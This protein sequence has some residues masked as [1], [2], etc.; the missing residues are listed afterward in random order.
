MTTAAPG[1]AAKREAAPDFLSAR[2]TVVFVIALGLLLWAS[3]GGASRAVI[4]GAFALY[5]VVATVWIRGQHEDALDGNR[6]F[7]P[8]TW[9]VALG[10][11]AAVLFGAGAVVTFW[12][13]AWP[14]LEIHAGTA[15]VVGAVLLYL[16]IGFLLVRWRE[17][18]PGIWLIAALIGGGAVAGAFGALRLGQAHIAWSL[19][20]L[21]VAL[22]ALPAGVALLSEEAIER[23]ATEHRR[24][25]PVWAL[26]SFLVF[27]GAACLVA[28]RL[29][30][31]LVL[32]ACAGLAGLVV[33]LASS[34]LADI[35]VVLALIAF[36]GITPRQAEIGEGLRPA[37]TGALVALGD[38]YMSG[39]GAATFFT[40]T[41]DGGANGCRRSPTAWAAVAGQHDF[42]GVHFLACSGAR[43]YNV[44]TEDED[45]GP[46][47][48]GQYDEGLSEAE[49]DADPRP[50][51]V[52]QLAQYEALT[53]GAAQAPGLVVISIG[54]NDVGFSTIGQMC[55]APGDCATK[56]DLWL[57]ALH[58]V[59]KEI[60]DTLRE[61]EG[62]FPEGTPIAVIPYPSP[63]YEPGPGEERTC[64][65]VALKASER[66]FISDFVD[67]LND[68]IRRAVP[69]DADMSFVG[70]MED[71]LR[72]NGLQLCDPLNGGRP[73]VNFIG[74]RSV[75]GDPSQRFN[76]AN[77]LHNSLHPNERGH[78]AM[79][80]VFREWWATRDGGRADSAPRA[81]AET[82]DV[83]G[84]LE[85]Q[86]YPAADE[87]RACRTLGGT[88]A[89]Q[90]TG[91]TLALAG[92][93]AGLL[94]AVAWVG[95]VCFFAWRRQ[96]WPDLQRSRWSRGSAAAAEDR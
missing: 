56:G 51:P 24:G 29:D 66:A 82:C 22:L 49:K 40:G 84:D 30:S 53:R 59:R 85:V 69:R 6:W 27:A 16:L 83:Y 88:W 70:G 13:E 15:L 11:G 43:T 26:A 31:P 9:T 47:P 46:V 38:S 96:R 87:S 14:V 12:V 10:A 58:D 95:S 68:T 92:S 89:L 37:S 76:P 62:A 78:A 41:D 32:V 73:G 7:L 5:A 44:R 42:A 45:G 80:G 20:P 2:R 48:H 75:N 28:Y 71:A 8:W 52:T 91:P 86:Y 4:A 50:E 74:I 67:A 60:R 63:I 61:V 55:V 77:W 3:Q 21:G 90:R 57:G 36:V 23:L 72:R 79:Y 93:V 19:V 1:P 94:A 65:D 34:T 18:S 54:G 39:E 81:V 33:A 17:S 35:A 25:L 64:D